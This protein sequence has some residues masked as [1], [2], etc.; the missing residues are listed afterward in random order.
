MNRA[1]YILLPWLFQAV[2]AS[3]QGVVTGHVSGSDGRSVEM[4]FVL[5]KAT[6]QSTNTDSDGRF[7]MEGVK[8]GDQTIIVH[9]VGFEQQHVPLVVRTGRISE[10][11]IVLPSL[12][13]LKAVEVTAEETGLRQSWLQP[14]DPKF[15]AIY[16]SKKTE[17]IQVEGKNA[18][19]ATNNARQIFNSI[20]G[21]N[22][23]ESDG[24]GLQLGIGG[25]GLSPNRTSNFNTRQNGYDISADALGYP[26][27]YYTPPAEAIESIQIVRGAASLQYGTQFGGMVNFV[28]KEGGEDPINVVSR[29]TVGSWGLFNTFNSIGGTA[30]NWNYYGFVQYKRGEGWRPNSGFEALTAYTALRYSFS[31]DLNIKLEYTHMNYDAQQPGGLTDALFEAD[32]RQSIRERNWFRVNWNLFALTSR[33]N[34]TQNAHFNVRLFGL[35]SRREA[36]GVLGQINR[37]DPGQERDLISGEFQNIGAEAR[38][39]QRYALVDY[40]P[41]TALVG[42]RYYRGFSHAQQ[43]LANDGDGPDFAFLDPGDVSGSDY[44][45]PSENLAV[46]A[47]NMFLL[48]E[49]LNITPGIRFEHISTRADGWFKNRNLHPLTGEVLFEETLYDQKRNDRNLLLL[50]LGAGYKVFRNVEVYANISQ[51][52]RSINFTDMQIT[53]PNFRID[54]NIRDERGYNADIGLRGGLGEWATF[55]LS[56][57][58][59]RYNNRIGLVQRVDDE[60]FNIYRLRTNVADS[61]TAGFESFVEVNLHPFF[62]PDSSRFK[63]SVFSNYAFINAQY[64][65][66]AE[67]AID[68]NRVELVPEHTLKAG[69]N[70]SFGQFGLSYQATYLSEQFTDATN[71]EFTSNAVNGIIPAYYV[72]DVSA[73][74]TYKMLRLEVGCN[75]LTDNYYFT[76]RAT[77][78]P[79]PGIIPSDGRSFYLT[80]QLQL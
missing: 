70:M 29:Q 79:G 30:G 72:M 38:Y 80:L 16:A 33:Y 57:F 73:S 11:N 47:E 6:G 62:A 3:G 52:Y 42:V 65:R 71:A 55:D 13:E 36:L 76:R 5:V 39:I 19:L 25:R 7:M 15:A 69:V 59:L 1:L 58:Y 63:C 45:F 68:Q 56:A 20:P 46:F 34:L 66:S 64:I 37:T 48:S 21:L 43:G 9:R 10:V 75:N 8:A 26:E 32:P 14:I 49:R 74:Y 4:A 60:L 31:E 27:S 77:G 23:W 35:L 67:P 18:N 41:S 40:L 44:A 17:S 50:G 22:I 51:N 78:Y 61:R 2:M 12:G 54:P 53:N 24:A 28:M